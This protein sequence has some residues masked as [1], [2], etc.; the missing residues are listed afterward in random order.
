M[1]PLFGLCHSYSLVRFSQGYDCAGNVV[2]NVP[3]VIV[4]NVCARFTTMNDVDQ[5]QC[6]GNYSDERWKVISTYTPQVC[7]SDFLEV[8]AGQYPNIKGVLPAYYRVVR[9]THP[10]DHT[11]CPHHTSILAELDTQP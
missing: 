4:G 2:N 11:C 10:N 9:V 8:P 7:D 5:I 1:I 3:G 6:F